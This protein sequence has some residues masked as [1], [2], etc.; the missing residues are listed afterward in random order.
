MRNRIASVLALI[1]FGVLTLSSTA[2]AQ[3]TERAIKVDIPFDFVVGDEIFPPGHYSVVMTAPAWLSLRDSNGRA[4]ATVLT[5]SGEPSGQLDRPKL[6]F[7]SEGGRHVL[8][9]VAQEGDSVSRQVLHSQ[10]ASLTVRK[11]S[12]HIQTADA[13]NPR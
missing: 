7:D 1:L 8:T 2:R 11:H 10:S 3:Q 9:Q 12:G 5:R 6:R 13:A 4:L